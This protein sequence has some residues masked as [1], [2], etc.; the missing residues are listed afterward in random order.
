MKD[1]CDEAI[2]RLAKGDKNA[3][4]EL[5][6]FYGKM[7]FSVAKQIVGNRADVED[8]LQD[9]MVKILKQVHNYKSGSNPKHGSWR[10]QDPARS[11]N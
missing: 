11:I 10:S 7:I 8:V 5:Y 2:C 3:L 6:Q 4:S 9:T 1:F